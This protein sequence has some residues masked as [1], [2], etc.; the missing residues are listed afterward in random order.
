MVRKRTKCSVDGGQ[1]QLQAARREGHAVDSESQDGVR[2]SP[3]GPRGEVLGHGRPL[4][5]VLPA[6]RALPPAVVRREV[7]DGTLVRRVHRDAQERVDRERPAERRELP[8]RPARTGLAARRGA[9]EP[10][11]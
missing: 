10:R 9:L 4:A 6:A 1:R 5:R 3:R 7:P 2:P 8:R 11:A